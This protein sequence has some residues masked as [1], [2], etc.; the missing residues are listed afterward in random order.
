MQERLWIWKRGK[1]GALS[2]HLV[3]LC[4]SASKFKNYFLVR[5]QIFHEIVHHFGVKHLHLLKLSKVFLNYLEP[6]CIW[7]IVTVCLPLSV[8][9]NEPV[10]WLEIADVYTINSLWK[11]FLEKLQDICILFLLDYLD[12][13]HLQMGSNLYPPLWLCVLKNDIHLC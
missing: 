12:R 9:A 6:L 2:L 7:N 5:H 8:R 4:Y 1:G 10:L 3:S 13:W 11:Y